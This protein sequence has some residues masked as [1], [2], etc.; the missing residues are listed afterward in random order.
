MTKSERLQALQTRIGKAVGDAVK[1]TSIEFGEWT[2]DLTVEAL[3][4]TCKKLLTGENFLF[5]TLIDVCGVD[6]LHYR[7]EAGEEWKQPRFAVVYHLLSLKHNRRLRQSNISL[8][9]EKNNADYCILT[10]PK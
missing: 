8:H 9:E 6:Y 1:A 10:Y 3:H 4:E 5:D 2:V 7:K